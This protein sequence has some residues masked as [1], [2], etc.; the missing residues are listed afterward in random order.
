MQ[1]KQLTNDYFNDDWAKSF[2]KISWDGTTYPQWLNDQV[3]AP[4]E[5]FLSNK[6]PT[7]KLYEGVI[8][9]KYF[10][11]PASVGIQFFMDTLGGKNNNLLHQAQ[12]QS[13]YPDPSYIQ[14]LS[15]DHQRKIFNDVI[16]ARRVGKI[17]TITNAI[18]DDKIRYP[19]NAIYDP[20]SQSMIC[21]PGTVRSVI[22]KTFGIEKVNVF[23]TD[24]TG[25]EN[26]PFMPELTE[27]VNMTDEASFSWSKF[28]DIDYVL[29]SH[30]LE[31]ESY[32]EEI[33]N[34][35]KKFYSFF[36][37]GKN[38]IFIDPIAKLS[39]SVKY[40]CDVHPAMFVSN[41]QDAG[42]SI[43]IDSKR[44]KDYVSEVDLDNLVSRALCC[45][46]AMRNYDSKY[47]QVKF[48][49]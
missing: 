42:V 10:S 25:T 20:V 27:V 39:D 45:V 3:D 19:V 11:A 36:V 32:I 5:F 22:L 37:L 44:Y 38:K 7:T 46:I 28:R 29:Q 1:P 47:I 9:S 33:L 12:L 40:L 30:E 35:Y 8:H 23:F 48:N 49:D 31:I 24:V 43:H 14:S 17:S 6:K 26:F 4:F 18:I 21:H 13:I 41:P 34:G 15:I 16:P 2:P